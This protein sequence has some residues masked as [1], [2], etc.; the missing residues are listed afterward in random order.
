MKNL[1][2]Y[3]K[4]VEIAESNI[5]DRDRSEYDDEAGM[6]MGN[7]KT[8]M[9][10]CDELL[11]TINRDENLPEWVQDKLAMAKQNISSI[12]DYMQSQHD[13]GIVYSQDKD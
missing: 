13:Q 1:R 6:V 3:I 12:A 11:N 4:L 7:L 2:D 8:I 9:R 5:P 10:S